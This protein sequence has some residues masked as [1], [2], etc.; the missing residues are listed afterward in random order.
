MSDTL[1]PL[2]FHW[3]AL[4]AAWGVAIYGIF[5]LTR[6]IRRMQAN[7]RDVAFGWWLGGT[8]C[9]GT[10]IW[11]QTFLGLLSV[12]WPIKMGYVPAVVLASWLPAVVISGVVIWLLSLPRLSWRLRALGGAFFGVGLSHLQ[13][14]S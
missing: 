13:L 7:D 2:P 4:L 6:V 8:L 5:L 11:A 3:P 9:I 14:L 12:R 1:L 10:G